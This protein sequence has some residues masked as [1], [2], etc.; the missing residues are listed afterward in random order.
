LSSGRTMNHAG[1][2]ASVRA[3]REELRHP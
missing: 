2:R 3:R 1:Y